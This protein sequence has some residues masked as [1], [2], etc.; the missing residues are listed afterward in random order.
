MSNVIPLSTPAPLFPEPAGRPGDWWEPVPMAT[1]AIVR[2]GREGMRR[3]LPVDLL[4]ALLVEHALV[5]S[6]ISGCPGDPLPAHAALGR[7]A[8]ELAAIGPGRL[9][10]AYVQML[11]GGERGYEHESDVQLARRDLVLPLRLHEQV[12][13]LDLP[14]AFECDRL[15]E[16]ISWEIAAASG[17]QFM[18]EWAL[19]TLLVQVA[20]QGKLV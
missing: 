3:R 15:D 9:H 13:D 10:T 16:A 17:G 19:S 7:A 6:D 5:I 12:R 8:T 18:R 4:A 11:R 1:A 20:S 14:K 2:L